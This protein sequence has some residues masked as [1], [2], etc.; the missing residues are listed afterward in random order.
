VAG[1]M[2]TCLRDL[3]SISCGTVDPPGSWPTI[4]ASCKILVIQ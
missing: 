1:S 3:A 2:P 4:P